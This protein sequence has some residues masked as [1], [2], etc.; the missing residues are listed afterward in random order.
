VNFRAQAPAW[1]SR[2]ALF[3]GLLLAA[4]AVGKGE[5]TVESESL[6]VPG[7]HEGSYSLDPN[8][9]AASYSSDSHFIRIERGNSPSQN[10]DALLIVVSQVEEIVGDRLG[11]SIPVGIA[12]ELLPEGLA[13]DSSPR[14]PIAM[15]LH[16]GE[17]CEE[18]VISLQAIS[19]TITFEHLF[20][21]DVGGASKKDRHIEAEFEVE[22]ADPRTLVADATSAEGY[23]APLASKL[24]GNFSFVYRRGSPAQTFP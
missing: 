14:S 18:E 3:G 4:C 13:S 1:P 21:G 5:G 7:C 17:T 8:Y 10:A 16:L 9:F 24:T 23:N 20:D 15:T 22:V 2:A 12:P 11:E 6:V 19:G